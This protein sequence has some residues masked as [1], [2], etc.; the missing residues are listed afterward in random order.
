LVR[1]GYTV[2]MIDQPARGRSPWQPDVVGKMTALPA[3]RIERLFTAPETFGNWPQ[4]KKHT[5]WPGNGRI[6]DP[7]F[8]AYPGAVPC[9][10]WRAPAPQPSRGRSPLGPHWSGD[11]ASVIGLPPSS[12]S[13]LLWLMSQVDQK[14]SFTSTRSNAA[15]CPLRD[16]RGRLR[17]G[18][19]RG[20]PTSGCGSKI[21]N[22]HTPI[23]QHADAGHIRLQLRSGCTSWAKNSM[24][25]SA[26][27]ETPC[28]VGSRTKY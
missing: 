15:L 6:G 9:R 10:Q 26:S 8:D 13:L 28:C 14:P 27:A 11:P 21:R 16:P 1:Q 12:P 17:I 4:A 5:P 23:S 24:A 22:F 7:A 25:S 2:Y 3:E 19:V 18:S 20:K